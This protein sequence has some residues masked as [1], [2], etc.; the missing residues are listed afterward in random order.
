MAAHNGRHAT[1]GP[2][3]YTRGGFEGGKKNKS[4]PGSGIRDQ[5]TGNWEQ[6]SVIREQGPGTRRRRKEWTWVPYLG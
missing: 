2:G 3:D 1:R 6:G 4:D 5:G